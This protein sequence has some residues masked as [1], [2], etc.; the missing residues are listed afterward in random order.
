VFA[1]A[2]LGIGAKV[3]VWPVG[4]RYVG[5]ELGHFR[6]GTMKVTLEIF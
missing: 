6:L 2:Y 4:N 1:E 3:V 5:H